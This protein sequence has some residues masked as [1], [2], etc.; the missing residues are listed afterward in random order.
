MNTKSIPS[1]RAVL[2]GASTLATGVV[3]NV[4]VTAAT[5]AAPALDP[6]K[7]LDPALT[8]IGHYRELQAKVDALDG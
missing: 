4:A 7:A 6:T 1:R 2:A 8:A 3:V 5:R